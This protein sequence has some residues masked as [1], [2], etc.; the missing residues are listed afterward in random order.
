MRRR[1]LKVDSMVRRRRALSLAIGLSVLSVPAFAQTAL[2]ELP[3]LSPIQAQA[4]NQL[5]IPYPF[6]DTLAPRRA[7]SAK[8][9]GLLGIGSSQSMFPSAGLPE[10]PG[11]APLVAERER[12]TKLPSTESMVVMAAASDS[13]VLASPIVAIDRSNKDIGNA[14]EPTHLPKPPV[15]KELPV[16]ESLSDPITDSLIDIE[17]PLEASTGRTGTSSPVPTVLVTEAP[18]P[19]LPVILPEASKARTPEL[20]RPSQGRGLSLEKSQ[21]QV[22]ASSKNQ[23][24]RGSRGDTGSINSV[25]SASNSGRKANSFSLKDDGNLSFSL[26]D[27]DDASAT[28]QEHVVENGEVKT[29]G[30]TATAARESLPMRVQI[31]GIPAPT[32]PAP[33]QK[34][35]AATVPRTRPSRPVPEFQ[36]PPA[37][38]ETPSQQGRARLASLAVSQDRL[39]AAATSLQTSEMKHGAAL[40]VG[41]KDTSLLQTE[42]DVAQVSVENPQVCQILQTGQ[43]T[44]SLVGLQPGTTRIAL[45]STLANGQRSVEIREVTVAGPRASATSNLD[46]LAQG[47][48]SSLEQLYPQYAIDI[49]VVDRS[50]LVQGEV[51]SEAEAKRIIAFVRKAS[52]T[53][54]IDKL[55]SQ[56]Q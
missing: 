33:Q 4:G 23:V 44:Y 56:E 12:H 18:V 36:A 35:T 28:S 48:L 50:L 54:V 53:P 42:T 41:I 8:V 39:P 46:G 16:Y 22:T 21:A 27:A 31:E 3:E 13:T 52:L 25:A 10:L 5:P 38:V 40:R 26:S 11:L 14:F 9:V 2:P 51:A 6:N 45:V 30:G 1:M 49:D 55:M 43:N 15:E 37:I 17:I 20:F 29:L 32:I 19:E 47:I 7:I 24:V 34:S